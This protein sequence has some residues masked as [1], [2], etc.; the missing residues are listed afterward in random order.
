MTEFNDLN[1]SGENVI[2]FKRSNTFSKV[3]RVTEETLDDSSIIDYLTQAKLE[4][5][6]TNTQEIKQK[7]NL[8]SIIKPAKSN[9]FK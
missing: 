7:E 6:C 4:E 9:N 5:T 8:T 2:I 1:D 3:P